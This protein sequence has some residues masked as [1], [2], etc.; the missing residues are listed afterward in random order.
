[1]VSAEVAFAQSELD[2]VHA[3]VTRLQ[4]GFADRKSAGR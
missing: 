3:K 1:M 2:D 4:A